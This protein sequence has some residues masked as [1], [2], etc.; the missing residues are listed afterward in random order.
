M[1]IH[2]H[3]NICSFGSLCVFQELDR[4]RKSVAL[5]ASPSSQPLAE[6]QMEANR[7]FLAVLDTYRESVVESVMAPSIHMSM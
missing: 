7:S 5:R 1:M 2:I 6:F 4:I 3:T